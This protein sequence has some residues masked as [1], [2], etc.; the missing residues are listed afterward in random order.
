M[1]VGWKRFYSYWLVSISRLSIFFP[2]V[3][4]FPLE[5]RELL[6]MH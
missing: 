3:I 5:Q 4:H 1:A 6:K 2:A